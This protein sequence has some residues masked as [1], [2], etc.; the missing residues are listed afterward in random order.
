MVHQWVFIPQP[1]YNA[2]YISSY[3]L[4]SGEPHGHAPWALLP[5]AYSQLEEGTLKWL[6]TK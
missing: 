2:D 6:R 4:T 5:L 3:A 1:F